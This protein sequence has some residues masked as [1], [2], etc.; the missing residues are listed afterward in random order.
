LDAAQVRRTNTS[1]RK[2]VIFNIGGRVAIFILQSKSSVNAFAL[3]ALDKF[4][5]PKAM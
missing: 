5:C 1:D 4:K 2:R 3:P